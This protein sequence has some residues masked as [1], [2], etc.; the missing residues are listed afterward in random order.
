MN[1]GPLTFSLKINKHYVQRDSRETTIG[2]SKWQDGADLSKCPT[3][4][5]YS[6]SSW[7]Y[8]LVLNKEVPSANFRVIHKEMG[9]G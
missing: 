4:E 2:D 3:M 9:T 1:Y 7:D 6:D 8:A 5:I